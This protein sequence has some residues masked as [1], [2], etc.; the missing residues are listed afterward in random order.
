MAYLQARANIARAGVTYG[1]WAPSDFTFTVGGTERTPLVRGFMIEERLDDTP[2]VCTFEAQGYTPTCGQTVTFAWT[3]PDAYWFAGTLVRRQM[4]LDPNEIPIWKCT[5]LD[6]TWLLNRYSKVTAQYRNLGINS[7]LA[8]VLTDFTNGGFLVGYCPSSLGT[9][10][11]FDCEDEDVSAVLSRL[12][13]AANAY[14]YI[15]PWKR[16]YLAATFPY[17][18]S[19]TITESNVFRNVEYDEDLTQLRNAT[20]VYGRQTQTTALVS[21]GATT[22]SVEDT[23]GFSPTGGT[24]RAGQNVITYTGLSAN[25]GPGTLTGCTGIVYEIAQGDPVTLRRRTDDVT[26]QTALATT[27]GGGLSGIVVHV[28]NNSLLNDSEADL[29]A[30]TDV[31]AFKDVPNGIAFDITD[32]ETAIGKIVTVSVTNPITI[33]DTF[34]VQSVSIV[35]HVHGGGTAAFT[36]KANARALLTQVATVLGQGR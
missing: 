23:R 22:V 2:G 35:P 36:R 19:L 20:I 27:L 31:A 1:G 32:R 21:G 34:R 8:R 14:W 28:I 29:V 24:A 13:A 26:A 3:T 18:N 25:S 12:A 16:V 10:D 17:G 7:I 33:S 15:D 6:Y 5:A 30:D 11:A 4:R 9:L